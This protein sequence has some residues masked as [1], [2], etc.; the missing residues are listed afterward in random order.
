MSKAPLAVGVAGLGALTALLGVIGLALLI[1]A[2][3]DGPATSLLIAAGVTGAITSVGVLVLLL[4]FERDQ[5]VLLREQRL[6]SQ[7]AAAALSPTGTLE[8]RMRDIE[9]AVTQQHEQSLEL[10][11]RTATELLGE[12]IDVRQSSAAL[13][14]ELGDL[15]ENVTEMDDRVRQVASS[16]DSADL[17]VRRRFDALYTQLEAL[18]HLETILGDEPP[19]PPLRGWALSPDAA[20][21]LVH[22]VIERRPATI[23]E[24]GSGTSSVL[25]GRA[26]RNLGKGH[27]TALEHDEEFAGRTRRLLAS[28]GLSEWVD[29]V[30]APLVEREAAGSTYRWYD[31]SALAELSDPIDILLVDGPPANTGP[32]ARLPALPLLRSSLADDAVV[33]LDDTARSEEQEV[34]ERWRALHP[35]ATVRTLDHEKGTVEFQF[36]SRA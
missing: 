12:M 27:V 21:H 9:D 3:A 8:A 15:T 11:R 19:L 6:R 35:E 17:A 2:G 22:T 14:T 29:V 4:W 16:V 31:T 32:L 1:T 33:L 10:W 18:S 24:L 36:G 28:H 23:V 13:R 26:V 34:V 20:L 7:A 30:S 5:L 25:L